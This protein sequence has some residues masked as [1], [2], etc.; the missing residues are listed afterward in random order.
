MTCLPKCFKKKQNWNFSA[1][2]NSQAT[3]T[4]AK[5]FNKFA[6]GIIKFVQNLSSEC[7]RIDILCDSYFD[8]YLKSHTSEARG[9]G[10]YFPFT[11]STN[12]PND[13][14]GNFFKAQ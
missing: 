7:S 10:Q 12:I 5:N 14:Q 9:C 8:N 13:F 11:E 2:V 3:V 6:G 1:I 4:T